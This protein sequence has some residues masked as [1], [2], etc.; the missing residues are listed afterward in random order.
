MYGL[1]FSRGG[2]FI[3]TQNRKIAKEDVAQPFVRQHSLIITFIWKGRKVD[4]LMEIIWVIVIVA[5]AFT[6]SML[7][8]IKR[9]KRTLEELAQRAVRFG[10][11]CYI[12]GIIPIQKV[13]RMAAFYLEEESIDSMQPGEAMQEIEECLK[14]NTEGEAETQN[15]EQ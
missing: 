6:A 12:E 3:R 11:N 2:G 7:L 4:C 9:R 10:E 14:K 8:N 1:S 15:Q 13:K 5:G